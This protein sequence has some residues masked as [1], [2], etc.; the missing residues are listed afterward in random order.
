MPLKDHMGIADRAEAMKYGKNNLDP[1]GGSVDLSPTKMALITRDNLN[2][3]LVF[4]YNPTTWSDSKSTEWSSDDDA[5]QF[6]GVG[7]REVSMEL[8]F[9]DTTLNSNNFEQGGG[10][11][12]PNK[13]T[14]GDL[15]A[16]SKRAS[17]A[18]S[19][20]GPF[21]RSA[22]SLNPGTR[23]GVHG[24]VSTTSSIGWLRSHSRTDENN[25]PESPPI[26]IFSGLRHK[27][28][29]LNLF[30][31]VLTKVDVTPIFMNKLNPWNVTRATVSITL[32]EFVESKA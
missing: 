31:C 2:D 17:S 3:Q 27:F 9:D 5:L 21:H 30:R 15:A 23:A 13:G 1:G 6:D 25:Y 14:H 24:Q 20:F 19:R 18:G 4:H 7:V 16:Q 28:N 8:F 11:V 10:Y 26:L 22:P 32:L 12:Q 29:R